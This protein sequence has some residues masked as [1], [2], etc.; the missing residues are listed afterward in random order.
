MVLADQEPGPSAGSAET[1]K[2][3]SALVPT[4]PQQ[5]E[6]GLCS[7]TRQQDPQ[8]CRSQT[9]ILKLKVCLCFM[10]KCVD[11]LMHIQHCYI[12]CTFTVWENRLQ[13]LLS[14]VNNNCAELKPSIQTGDVGYHFLS[15]QYQYE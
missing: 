3:T 11:A 14:I 13:T 4:E 5:Q 2:Q 7:T 1:A 6:A 10:W 9:Q 8:T 12:I 15:D